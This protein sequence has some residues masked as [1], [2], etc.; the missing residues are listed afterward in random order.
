MT[1]ICDFQALKPRFKLAVWRIQSRHRRYD[2]SNCPRFSKISNSSEHNLP[3]LVRHSFT[4]SFTWKSTSRTR[5]LCT[6]PKQ[7][8]TPVW[9]C[10]FSGAHVPQSNVQRWNVE[11]GRCF[12]NEHVKRKKQKNGNEGRNCTFFLIYLL[13]SS[14]IYEICQQEPFMISYLDNLATC[15]NRTDNC[16]F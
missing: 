6:T 4:S 5:K 14:R 13:T 8:R 12:E 10:C 15:Y 2:P 16:W 1:K 7:T 9:I 11:V 3:G